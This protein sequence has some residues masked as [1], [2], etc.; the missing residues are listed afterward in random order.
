LAFEEQNMKSFEEIIK[1]SKLSERESRILNQILNL[2]VC[3]VVEMP[4]ASEIMESEI[5][6]EKYNELREIMKTHG[7]TKLRDLDEG[8]IG[9]ILGGIAGFVV[10][11][12]IGKV[13]ANALGIE[14]GILYDMFTSRLV[15]AALGAAITKHI[16]K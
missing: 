13:I 12:S 2:R 6:L 4:N 15:G 16:G 9:K 14:K 11:P 10:G 3:E 8:M 5:N 1:E 7:E